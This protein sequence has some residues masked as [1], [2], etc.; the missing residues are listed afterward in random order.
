M[1]DL[2]NLPDSLT[3]YDLNESW[4]ALKS[5]ADKMRSEG[6]ATNN[7]VMLSIADN[8]DNIANKMRGIMKHLSG[9]PDLKM[10]VI[11]P[12]EKKVFDYAFRD[13]LGIKTF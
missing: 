5:S 11:D 12:N 2:N 6:K 3:F 9:K 7:E 4:A 13:T 1:T 8:Y 10:V